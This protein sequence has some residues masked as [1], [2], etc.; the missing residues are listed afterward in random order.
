MVEIWLAI[1][2]LIVCF[3]LL[4]AIGGGTLCTEIV[5][6]IIRAVWNVLW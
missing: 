4:A 6:T 1:S 5:W 2:Q 3:T